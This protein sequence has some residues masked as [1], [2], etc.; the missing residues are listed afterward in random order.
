MHSG[1]MCDETSDAT[2]FVAP[3]GIMPTIKTLYV[4][5]HSHTD[6][7]FTDYQ[8][9]CYRQHRLFIDQALELIEATQDYPGEAQ[10]RWVCE[11]TGMTEKYFARASSAQVERF[12]R[13]HDLGFIDIAGMQYNHT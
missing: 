11:V 10:Y 8:D 3:G 1:S 7:G 13:W 9:L 5:N 12:K 6:I 2:Q 4:V